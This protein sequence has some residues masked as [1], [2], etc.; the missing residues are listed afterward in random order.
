MAFPDMG[1]ITPEHLAWLGIGFG[2]GVLVSLVL[3]RAGLFFFSGQYKK[4]ADQALYKNSSRFMELADQYFSSYVRE[5]GKDLNIHRDEIRHTIDPIK[6][7]LTRYEARLSDMERQRETAY[8]AISEKLLEVGRTQHLLYMETGNLV[9][10][11]RQPHVRGR[12]GEMTLRRVAELSGMAAHCDFEEQVTGAGDKGLV[13]PDMVVTLPSSRKVIVDAKVPLMA[14]LDALEADNET[15]RAA[16]MVDHARQVM[17][18]VTTLGSKRYQAHFSP[19]PEF[20]V[21]FI[22]GENFFSAALEQQPDLIERAVE[23]GVIPATP[24]TLI[25]LLKAVSYSWLQK[26]TYENAEE[27]R[28]MGIELYARLAGMADHMNQLG[29]DIE[30]CAA[31]FNRTV[32]TMERRVMP[33]ARKLEALGPGA[34]K[35][36][37]LAFLDESKTS[38]RQVRSDQTEGVR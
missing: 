20:V 11:L 18:H 28:E 8:G 19:T 10:A 9:K 15:E 31:S 21:L 33:S 32:G 22:P 6:Q 36:M 30:K 4:A 1:S 38:A 29:K 23:K 24:T 25:A 13:R 16:R 35:S 3:V 26:K 17:A 34:G 2:L 7:T 37:G 27:I 5:A 12:W 14:F